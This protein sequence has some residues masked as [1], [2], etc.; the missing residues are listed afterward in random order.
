MNYPISF[1]FVSCPELLTCSK[2]NYCATHFNIWILLAEPRTNML[3]ILI[4]PYS[5]MGAR[6]CLSLPGEQM[7]ATHEPTTPPLPGDYILQR[8]SNILVSRILY[9]TKGVLR[10]STWHMYRTPEHRLSSATLSPRRS[11]TENQ[12]RAGK[13]GEWGPTLGDGKEGIWEGRRMSR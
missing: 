10:S 4:Y 6:V 12:Q 11:P 9:M 2:Q 13:G 8:F 1:T 7:R 3:L 5:D